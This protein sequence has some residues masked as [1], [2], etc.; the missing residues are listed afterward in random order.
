M[1]EHT[2]IS[3]TTNAKTFRLPDV[4]QISLSNFTSLGA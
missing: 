4:Q 3:V 1:K 2:T